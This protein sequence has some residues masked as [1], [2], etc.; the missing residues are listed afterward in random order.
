[1]GRSFSQI[2]WAIRGVHWIPHWASPVFLDS[3]IRSNGLKDGVGGKALKRLTFDECGTTFF[4]FFF[5]EIWMSNLKDFFYHILPFFPNKLF[6]SLCLQCLVQISGTKWICWTELM[7]P[8]G[9]EGGVGGWGEC[10]NGRWFNYQ[11]FDGQN[12]L[13]A[14]KTGCITT[15]LLQWTWRLLVQGPWVF[16]GV[17]LWSLDLQA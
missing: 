5:P 15:S 17:A 4:L 8:C 10:L 14:H 12:T 7:C 6:C 13:S 9:R 2:L 3:I 1:M 11:G 16:T